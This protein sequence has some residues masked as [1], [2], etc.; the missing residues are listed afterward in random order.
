MVQ[1]AP[2]GGIRQVSRRVSLPISGYLDRYTVPAYCQTA[3][4]VQV[5]TWGS[6]WS[7]S[8]SPEAGRRMARQKPGKKVDGKRA[9]KGGDRRAPDPGRRRLVVVG[10]GAAVA[11]LGLAGWALWRRSDSPAATS[12][13]INGDPTSRPRGVSLPPRVVPADRVS[14]RQ[15]AEEMLTHYT[16]DLVNPSSII[17]AIR[18]LG[19]GFRLADGTN[20]VDHLCSRYALDREAGGQRVVYFQ[21]EAEVHENSFLKT[22]LEAG[23]PESQPIFA[24]GR[25]YRLSDLARSGQALFR[26]DPADLYRFDA[27]QYRYDSAFV[28]PRPPGSADDADGAGSGEL[29][30]E[31]LPWGLIAFSRLVSPERP[32]WTNAFGETIDLHAVLDRS[33]AA[34]E[35][36]CALGQEAMSRGEIAPANFRTAIKKYSCFGLHTVYCYLVAWQRGH[37]AHD[38][39]NRMKWMIDLLT[40]RL[41]SDA[42]AIVEDYAREARGASSPLVDAFSTRALVKLYGHAFEAINYAKLHRLIEFTPSQERRI[43]AGEQALYESI[44]RLRAMDWA[45]LRAQLGDKFISDIVIALGHAVRGMRL[46]TPENPDLQS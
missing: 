18:G 19:R 9:A 37:V 2:H 5:G 10:S 33:L 30:H 36:T 42:L 28:P 15:A 13:S 11:G 22:F 24:S 20:A 44:V 17:H 1:S 43:E 29:I 6:A 40:Y 45:M 38:L 25:P 32:T 39:P 4:Q 34:Y 21:R 46:L 35:S 41:K 23:V 27:R 7:K 14:A 8:E 3:R 26:C 31:H 12:S 16:N